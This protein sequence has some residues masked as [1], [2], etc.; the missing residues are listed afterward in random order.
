M[1]DLSILIPV[2]NAAP[3]LEACVESLFQQDLPEEQ[4]EVLLIDDGSTDDSPAVMARLAEAHPQVRLLTQPNQGVSAA[5]NRGLREAEGEYLLFVDADD[6]LVPHA[7]PALLRA[8]RTQ[9]ADMVM[10]GFLTVT[11]DDDETPRLTEDDDT[12]RPA[13]TGQEAYLTLYSPLQCTVW[14]S[15]FRT[16]FLREHHIRFLPG[17]RMAE[18]L[19]VTERCLLL[20]RRVSAVARPFYVYHLRPHSCITSMTPAKLCDMNTVLGVMQREHTALA[21]L[22]ATQK[23]QAEHLAHHVMV[24]VWYLTH[25]RSLYAARRRV[26]D[27]LL[28]KVA[29]DLRP[30]PAWQ[31]LQLWALRRCP[32]TLLALRYALARHKYD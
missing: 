7:L 3:Y 23:R 27:D 19:E 1:I 31:R 18:D 4:F 29:R 24:V 14:Q 32:M 25:H 10:G 9:M 11:G 15:L 28:H 21:T 30:L 2:F 5:R 26:V 6:T 12:P 17:I 16:D 20:A 22:P 13:I 8:A